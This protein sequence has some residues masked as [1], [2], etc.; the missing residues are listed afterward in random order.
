MAWDEYGIP[1]SP[2]RFTRIYWFS[3]VELKHLLISALLV[4]GV[5][6]STLLYSWR[7]RQL[8]LA[9]PEAW[10]FL[11]VIFA[12][13]FLLH[14]IAH[15]LVAQHFGLWA[16][17]RLTTFGAFLT[18]LSIVSPIKIVCPGA[19]VVSGY[20]SR[21]VM[22]KT[23]IAGPIT[24][25]LLSIIFLSAMA[26]TRNPVLHVVSGIAA[27]FNAWISLFNLIPLGVLDGAKVLW[28]NKV[29]WI[30]SFAASLILAVLASTHVF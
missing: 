26:F 10:L 13:T 4:V 17:F 20:V 30:L 9:F 24:N 18:L 29:A 23:S 19:V 22:G 25:I 27:A 11:T 6:L 8:A 21:E 15:K 12:M 2:R 7:L 28:W 1:Y 3:S 14:E 5:G 16:E